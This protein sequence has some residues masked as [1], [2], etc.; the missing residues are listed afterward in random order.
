MEN[1]SSLIAHITSL[2]GFDPTKARIVKH[3][4]LKASPSEF[5][6]QT[7]EQNALDLLPTAAEALLPWRRDKSYL[8]FGTCW[9][10]LKVRKFKKDK[11]TVDILFNNYKILDD[12]TK[13]HN[14]I[15]DIVNILVISSCSSSCSA[16]GRI[17]FCPYFKVL[18]Q[19]LEMIYLIITYIITKKKN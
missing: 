18:I 4:S 14:F 2:P 7:K 13:K 6:T 5:Q 9:I 8:C 15:W 11:N 12:S 3:L 19:G 10:K 16:V 1:K 17:L